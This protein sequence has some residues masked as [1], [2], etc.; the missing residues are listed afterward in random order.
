[1]SWDSPLVTVGTPVSSDQ[2]NNSLAVFMHIGLWRWVSMSR[3]FNFLGVTFSLLIVQLYFY[4]KAITDLWHS[5][6][7]QACG[8]HIQSS[9]ASIYTQLPGN[10]ACKNHYFCFPRN[11][12]H[13]ATGA[14]CWRNLAFEAVINHSQ[15]LSWFLALATSWQ[16]LHWHNSCSQDRKSTVARIPAS[17]HLLCVKN[18]HL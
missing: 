7:L 1:M 3:I 8:K 5:R 9:L 14:D 17:I 15:G 12:Y 13:Q 2:T 10:N 4:S 16:A 6:F 18:G 11:S